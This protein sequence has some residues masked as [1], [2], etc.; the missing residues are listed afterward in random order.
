MEYNSIADIYSANQKIREHLNAKLQT[1]TP[2]E[3][4]AQPEGE[5]WTI[6]HIVEHLWM[7]EFG[8]SRLCSRLLEAAMADGKPSDGSYTISDS[9]ARRAAEI[10]V[11]KV[12]APDRVQPKGE[13][14]IEQSIERMQANRSDLEA[15]RADLER[16]DM[17]AHTFAH[18]FF[19]ELTA[20]E[21]LVM[22]GWHERRHT[23]QL[24][25]VL[26]RVR[27]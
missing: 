8:V 24:Q 6:E 11:I 16:F 26:D 19:G 25:R 18:P 2:E 15:L 14:T 9:F 4:I 7:V 12:E 21:W 27:A 20:P 1:I 23:E 5:K 10:A 13:T 22:L 17:S 3:A